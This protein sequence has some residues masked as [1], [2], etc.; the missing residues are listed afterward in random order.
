M[1]EIL[2]RQEFNE[3]IPARLPQSVKVAHKTGSINGLYHDFGIVF[4][5]G[6]KPY[7]L[8]VMTRGFENESDAHECVAEVSSRIYRWIL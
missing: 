8:A 1:I 5:E 2:L 4:S 7:I 3:G 6:R